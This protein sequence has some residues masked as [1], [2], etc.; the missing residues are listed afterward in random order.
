[1]LSSK[2]QHRPTEI[3]PNCRIS[4]TYLRNL[5]RCQ[6]PGFPI[7]EFRRQIVILVRARR[8]PDDLARELEPT[9]HS[10]RAWVAE[11]DDKADRRE[12][13]IAGLGPTDREELTRLRR[14]VP[15]LRVKR[16]IL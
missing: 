7:P 4:R 9:A 11:A 10:I 13:V 14:E 15:Q 2:D 6:E 3:D 1:M 5:S 8:G 16:S 12:G